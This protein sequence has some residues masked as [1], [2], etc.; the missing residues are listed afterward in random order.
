M[1]TY[2]CILNNKCWANAVISFQAAG[3]AVKRATD[4]L[5]KAAIAAKGGSYQS[6]EV[7]VKVNQRMVGGMAQVTLI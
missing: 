1:R 3:N 5:V 4:A 2:N 6:E 7:N